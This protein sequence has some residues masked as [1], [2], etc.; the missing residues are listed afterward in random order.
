[1]TSQERK[2]HAACRVDALIAQH[3]SMR[4][5]HQ[6]KYWRLIH[7]IRSRTTLLS[8]GQQAGFLNPVNAGAVIQACVRMARRGFAWIRSPEDW[9][10]PKGNSLVQFRSLVHHLYD[11]YSVP[12]F[13]TTVWWNEH[14]ISWELDLYLHLARGQSV[15]KYQNIF[16]QRLSKKMA[17]QFMQAPDDLRP[18]TAIFWSQVRALGADDS[19]AR[20][21]STRTLLSL[22]RYDTPFW[23]SVIHFLVKYQPISVDETVEIVNF[24]FQQRYEPAEKVWGP[25]AGETPVQPQFS[26]KG[27][28]LMSLRRHMVHWQSD[29]IEQGMM[30]P[31]GVSRL[32]F[33]WDRC[34]IR[35]YHCE[36]EDAVWSIEELLT[37]RQLQNESRRM[38]HCVSDY[39]GA[40]IGRS[41]TIWSMKVKT[42]R[43]R[44]RQLTIEVHPQKKII[45]QASGKNNCDPSGTVKDI[46]N[47]WAAQ[48]GLTL[49]ESI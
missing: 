44:R 24:V 32:D 14:E 30:P 23:N 13:M 18:Y 34:S 43:R 12:E 9:V 48:E 47:R 42:G 16:C 33:P 31:P 29:L 10:V 2:N 26:L 25:G 4:R 46:L 38:N 7:V 37:P 8:P 27:R 49:N 11:K 40:C 20:I 22:P 41:T 28:S 1:M 39:I 5:A 35:A 19:L 6:K 36:Q 17:A 45:F 3:A 21:L 15:R